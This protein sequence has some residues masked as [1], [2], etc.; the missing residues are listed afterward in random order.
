MAVNIA[1]RI[2]L[3]FALLAGMGCVG[4][5]GLQGVRYHDAEMIKAVGEDGI[6]AGDAGFAL[7]MAEADASGA[8]GAPHPRFHPVP[9]RPVFEP[10][11]VVGTAAA[12]MPVESEP[13]TPTTAKREAN[14]H[15]APSVLTALAEK[16]TPLPAD[17]EGEDDTQVIESNEESVATT[18]SRR[19]AE[20]D[21]AGEQVESSTKPSVHQ[22]MSTEDEKEVVTA[23]HDEPPAFTPVKTKAP[24]SND[25]WRP[26]VG[27]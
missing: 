18:S 23:T 14:I 6:P 5:Q 4:C 27:N 26:R 12:P 17:A 9:T 1:H 25:M 10:E 8:T 22:A 20:D 7:G 21:P 24:S 2:Y 13:I 11:G 19:Q 16:A 3:F 15:E